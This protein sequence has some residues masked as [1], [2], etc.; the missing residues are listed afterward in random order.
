MR[1]FDAANEASSPS[2]LSLMVVGV[3]LRLILPVGDPV[4]TSVAMTIRSPKTG[5]PLS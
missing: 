1:V 4:E 5:S 3:G 2:S